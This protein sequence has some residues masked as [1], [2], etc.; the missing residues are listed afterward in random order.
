MPSMYKVFPLA[1]SALGIV[2]CAEHAGGGFEFRL[3]LG[4]GLSLPADLAIPAG[5]S[6]ADGA[7]GDFADSAGI[8]LVDSDSGR[9]VLSYLA[10]CALPSGA[11][12]QGVDADGVSHAF[13]GKVGLAASW[14]H[15]TCDGECRGWV[16][17]CMLARTNARGMTVQISMEG[18]HPALAGEEPLPHNEGAFFGD[19][20]GGKL[21]SCTGPDADLAVAQGRV[22]ATD[23]DEC[24]IESVGDCA[25]VC[26]GDEGAYTACSAGGETFGQVINT[27]VG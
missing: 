8:P 11:S 21:Y 13:A 24:I 2:G 16:S 19:L 17:A 22:C 14:G 9:A 12:V 26:Q 5:V 10:A 27:F 3:L 25:D 18:S 4:N 15:G 23:T 20:G 1:F 7:N 6:L